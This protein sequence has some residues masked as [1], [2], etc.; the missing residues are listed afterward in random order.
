MSCSLRIVSEWLLETAGHLREG[1]SM[2]GQLRLDR[3]LTVLSSWREYQ[4]REI[5]SG[6]LRLLMMANLF[7]KFIYVVTLVQ[8]VVD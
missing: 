8:Q 4:E 1:P 6:D 2:R 5:E 7:P 3:V